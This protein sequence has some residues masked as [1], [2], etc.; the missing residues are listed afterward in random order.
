MQFYFSAIALPRTFYDPFFAILVLLFRLPFLPITRQLPKSWNRV[1]FILLCA[2][3]GFG[4]S[5][6]NVAQLTRDYMRG[7]YCYPDS[8]LNYFMLWIVGGT[9]FY[10]IGQFFS[11]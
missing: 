10:Q 2:S 1:Y 7:A 9:A 11:H 5:Q 8:K 4:I 3:V 6:L